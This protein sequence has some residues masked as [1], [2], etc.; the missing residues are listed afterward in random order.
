[1]VCLIDYLTFS[2][3]LH[4]LIQVLNVLGFSD[5]SGWQEIKGNY[6]YQKAIFYGGIRI[7]YAGRFDMGICVSM[8]GE[9]CRTIENNKEHD[10]IKLFELLLSSDKINITRLDVAF[11]DTEGLLNISKVARYTLA[12]KWSGKFKSY[13]VTE[14]SQG[15]SVYFGSPSSDIRLRIY[16]KAAERGFKDGRHWVRTE[17]Q[18]RDDIATAM[19]KAIVKGNANGGDIGRI[20]CGVVNNY[21]R[22]IN[23]ER[24]RNER[25]ETVGWWAEFLNT[26]EKIRLF[27]KVGTVYNLP[28]IENYLKKQAGNSVYTYV[29]CM[30]GDLEPLIELVKARRKKLSRKQEALINQYIRDGLI[31]GYL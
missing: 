2:S 1:M 19:C 23:S 25:C 21:V 3:K 10:W 7:Y 18:M 28:H 9:G 24:T 17:L 20:F 12:L 29:T 4:T 16:D 27:Q 30:G 6:G 8:S 15:T 26:T 11:D 5:I 22:F 14:G 31:D 13:S